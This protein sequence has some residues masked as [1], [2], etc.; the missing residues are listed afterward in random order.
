MLPILLTSE[1]T[2]RVIASYA[3]LGGSFVDEARIVHMTCSKTTTV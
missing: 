1:N 2:F 3:D